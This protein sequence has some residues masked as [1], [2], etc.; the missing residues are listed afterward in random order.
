VIAQIPDTLHACAAVSQERWRACS[1][2][3]NAS[4]TVAHIRYLLD[5]ERMKCAAQQVSCYIAQLRLAQ[6]LLTRPWQGP[7]G[8]ATGDFRYNETRNSL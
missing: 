8:A 5:D 2:P 6:H 4:K 3:H 1:L 7:H